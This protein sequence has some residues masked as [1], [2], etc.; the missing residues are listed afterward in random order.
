MSVLNLPANSPN[1]KNLKF[2]NF[3][4]AKS[5]LM[6]SEEFYNLE[7]EALVKFIWLKK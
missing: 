7:E 4:R 1:R 2:L 3:L 5:G 6:T